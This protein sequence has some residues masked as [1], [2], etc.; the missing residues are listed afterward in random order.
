[1]GLRAGFEKL[2]PDLSQTLLRFPIP[3]LCAIAI[4]ILVEIEGSLGSSI[5]QLVLGGVAAFFAGGIGHLIA[6]SRG[7]D[8]V[9][10]WLA[11]TVLG[12]AAFVLAY[13]SHLFSTQ[14]A[15]LFLG[16]VPLLM[17]A[18]YLGRTAHQGA[19]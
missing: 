2:V 19:L 10:N 3:A 17:I 4:T 7:L 11:A 9:T 16:L 13:L 14:P 12:I 6:E 18:P 1:M 5:N 8:R 15:F